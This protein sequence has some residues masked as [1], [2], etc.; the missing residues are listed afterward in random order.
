M[1]PS[2]YLLPVPAH[3]N[4]RGIRYPDSLPWF[5]GP[6]PVPR[7]A[8]G[9]LPI[10]L[11]ISRCI[12]LSHGEG[13]RS[14]VPIVTDEGTR[15]H[16]IACSRYHS[17]LGRRPIGWT[18]PTPRCVQRT[19]RATLVSTSEQFASPALK[20]TDTLPPS[21]RSLPSSSLTSEGTRQFLGLT[22][23]RTGPVERANKNNLNEHLQVPEESL[24]AGAV[25]VVREVQKIDPHPFPQSVFPRPLPTTG[26]LRTLRRLPLAELEVANVSKLV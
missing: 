14:V 22:V 17:S 7:P 20:H 3:K 13:T 6:P 21:R 19:L 23:K 16:A 12:L 26:H 24:L 9:T 11:L 5:A 18:V 1:R 4:L 10:P 15:T 2:T 8:S 25:G